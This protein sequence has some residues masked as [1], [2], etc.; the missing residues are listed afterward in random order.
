MSRRGVLAGVLAL[1]GILV[2]VVLLAR[3]R[4]AS[5]H[6][7][8]ADEVVADAAPPADEP[9]THE[10][11]AGLPEPARRYFETVLTE[12]QPY[13]ET[14]RVRQDGQLR[15]GDADS[16]WKPMTATNTV[17]VSP[18]GF[19]WDAEVE[20]APFL[21]V[22]V[23][24]TYHDGEGYLRAKLLSLVTV[25]ED[26]PGPEMDEG[27]LLRYLAEAPW[28]P[29]ALLP[30]SGVTWESVSDTAARATLTDGDTTVSAVFH[31]D[32]EH[33]VE[34][35]VADRPRATDDGYERTRWIGRFSDYE[36]HGGM[37]VPTAGEVAWDLPD[38][39]L[40]YWRATVSGFDYRPALND[41]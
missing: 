16:A 21:P 13:V 23:V 15:L 22:S 31:F 11:L 34:R 6:E 25:A 41:D 12:G 4:L 9:F 20:M 3:A 36:R 18:P 29:T 8:L 27:E 19:V 35:V 17:S 10:N 26:G 33:R 7:Q 38:G 5:A 1:V 30:E 14:A 2:G 39:D 40:P 24:D 32:D 28:Y 37:V